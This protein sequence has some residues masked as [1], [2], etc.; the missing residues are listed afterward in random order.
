[1]FHTLEELNQALQQG[2]TVFNDRK[3]TG[4][5]QSRRQLFESV[6]KD[7][8]AAFAGCTPSDE[9]TQV[10]DSD[11]QQLYDSGKTSLQRAHQ[12]HWGKGRAGI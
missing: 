10:A 4:R 8:T 7:Y 12:I 11:A 9:T 3:L 5:N 1:M 2:L 6:E